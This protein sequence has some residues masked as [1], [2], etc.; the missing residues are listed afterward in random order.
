MA[1][2]DISIS[3]TDFIEFGVALGVEAGQLEEQWGAVFGRFNK[4]VKKLVLDTLRQSQY[5]LEKLAYAVSQT[6]SRSMRE[7]IDAIQNG[8]LTE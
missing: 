8:K 6:S 4:A 3:F 2:N 1:Y 5:P 7:T